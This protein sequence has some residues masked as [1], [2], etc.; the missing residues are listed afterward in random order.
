MVTLT[1]RLLLAVSSMLAAAG[2]VIHAAPFNRALS[3]IRVAN[4]K[5]FYA[6]SFK[7]LWLGDSTTLF[8]VAVLFALFAARPSVA[9]KPVVLLVALIPGAVAVLIYVFLGNF[10]AGHLLMALPLLHLRRALDFRFQL[11]EAMQNSLPSTP[12]LRVAT[13]GNPR[14]VRLE[15]GTA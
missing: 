3:A 5:P 2:A 12:R 6:N 9:T 7:A 15:T 1:P 10:F 8:T 4:L 14:S 11:W 13:S